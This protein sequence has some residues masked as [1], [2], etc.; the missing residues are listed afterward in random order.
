MRNWLYS[1]PSTLSSS[2]DQH[3]S[4]E[5]LRL[6]EEERQDAKR[7]AAEVKRLEKKKRIR[8]AAE[9]ERLQQVEQERPRK[10]LEEQKHPVEQSLVRANGGQ[11]SLNEIQT[12]HSQPVPINTGQPR[13][14]HAGIED[15]LGGDVPSPGSSEREASND[16]IE[17]QYQDHD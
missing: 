6:G 1:G 10:I 8:E 16:H 15:F 9:R 14:G 4:T 5:S 11:D 12:S 13:G 2:I 7:K 3:R 17:Y